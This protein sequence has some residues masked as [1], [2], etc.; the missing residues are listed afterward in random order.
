MKSVTGGQDISI[1]SEFSERTHVK[2]IDPTDL[3]STGKRA[4]LQPPSSLGDE[5]WIVFDTH[6]RD[7][8]T[9]TERKQ[10]LHIAAAQV[11]YLPRP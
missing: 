4:L 8:Q 11:Q 5:D 9:F 6:T 10:E 3:D 2:H 1:G 7:R